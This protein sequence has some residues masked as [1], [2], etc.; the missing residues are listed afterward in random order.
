MEGFRM[1]RGR[2][3]FGFMDC[4]KVALASRGM[5]VGVE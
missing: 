3:R 1:V 5:T 2:P 4:V